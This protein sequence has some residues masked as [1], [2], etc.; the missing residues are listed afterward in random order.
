MKYGNSTHGSLAELIEARKFNFMNPDITDKRFPTPDRLWNDYKGFCFGEKVSSEEAVKRMQAEGYE[1]ANSHELVLWDGW[2]GKDTVVALGSVTKVCGFRFVLG[3]NRDG[4]ER[5]I[6]LYC[7]G[8]G[9]NADYRFLA[10]R[11]SAS[12]GTGKSSGS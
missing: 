8:F 4:S 9:W 1:S 2:N 6:N 12:L 10:V 11:P 5:D 7:W 3:L